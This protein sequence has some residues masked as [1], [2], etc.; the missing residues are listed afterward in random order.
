L[1]ISEK[2]L[3]L[4]MDQS[5]S[6]SPPL[7]LSSHHHC[8]DRHRGFAFVDY[9]ESDDAEAAIQNMN[10]AEVLGK[11]IKCTIAKPL[12]KLKPGQALWS[13]EEFYE[14]AAHPDGESEVPP[15]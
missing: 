3:F 11:F 6:P 5:V 9:E 12:T 13:T 14:S 4:K 2:L 1:A 7:P 8:P 10:G 15:S